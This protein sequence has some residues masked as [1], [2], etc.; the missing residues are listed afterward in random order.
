MMIRR[1]VMEEKNR[2]LGY[3]SLAW[4]TNTFFFFLYYT[5]VLY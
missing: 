4:H 5:L 2:K 3:K 1:R